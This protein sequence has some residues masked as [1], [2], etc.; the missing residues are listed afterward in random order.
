MVLRPPV[1]PMLAQAR[2]Q[3][4]APGPLPGQL[5]FQPKV[6]G[7]RALVFTPCPAPGPVL[8]QSRQGSLIQSRFP[9]LSA[10]AGHLPDGLVLDGVT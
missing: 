1:E 9:D 6:D 3:L 2:D 5:V 7:Y 8:I 4:P 10:A